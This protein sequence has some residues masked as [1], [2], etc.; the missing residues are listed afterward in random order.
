MTDAS[1]TM[2]EAI[3][4]KV[5]RRE[6]RV[7]VVGLG[8]VGLPLA[9]RFAS[10]GFP[11]VGLDLDARKVAA[12]EAG[13]SY[14]P[15]VPSAEI[16]AAVAAKTLRASRDPAVLA[17]ADFVSVCV[18]T[19]LSKFREPDLSAVMSVTESIQRHLRP[20][21]VISYESTTYPGTTDEAVE[22]Q[23]ARTGLKPGRDYFLAFSPERI[24]PGR[25]DF[26]LQTTPKVVGGVTP[27]CTEAA[28]ACYGAVIDRVVRVSSARAAEMAKMLENTFR[29]VNIGL[30]NEMAIICDRL[31]IPIFEVIQAASTK[32]FGFMPFFP[33]P[34]LGGHCLPIDPL[35]LSWKMRSLDYR[36][37]FIEIAEEVNRSMPAYVVS[38]VAA[39]LNAKKKAV[40]G[41]RVLVLGAAYKKN[42]DDVR[43][44]PAI[45]V[46]KQLRDLGADV[47]YHDPYIATLEHEGL[48]LRSVPLDD[49]RLRACDCAVV[50]TDHSCFDWARIV[51]SA[52]IVVDTR[53]ATA[54]VRDRGE[55]VLL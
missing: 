50:V 29:S 42:I 10:C 38:K 53:N 48:P 17:D 37:R 36:A 54:A 55:V 18:P 39:A 27:S 44:S 34:G 1:R 49:A 33:G 35:Y 20:G 43:E 52:P 40:N 19:P 12:I 14:I 9:A 22:P 2:L 5:A 13:T 51:S 8:Y 11:V 23:L 24:D 15:D 45:D 25:K 46:I 6:L 26:T 28:A 16:A 30:V 41:S 4:T 21:Q 32:P 47:E 3:T 31:K 7:A